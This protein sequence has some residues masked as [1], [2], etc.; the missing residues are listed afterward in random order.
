MRT[1]LAWLKLNEEIV[2]IAEDYRSA[3]R[4]KAAAGKQGDIVDLP[5]GLIAA[6]A[7]KLGRPL[8]TGNTKHFR[9]I[10]NTGIIPLTIE[11]WRDI[12]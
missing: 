1:F 6:V 4:I 2:P 3:A 10:Q 12:V 7:A 9:A 5:D 11:N 8:V